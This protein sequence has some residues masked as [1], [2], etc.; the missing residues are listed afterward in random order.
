MARCGRALPQGTWTQVSD[1]G[2]YTHPK[3]RKNYR[4]E[5]C[6]QIIPKGEAH[7]VFTGM[8]ENEFQYWRMHDECKAGA[9]LNGDMHDGFTPYEA[10]RPPKLTLTAEPIRTVPQ[11]DHTCTART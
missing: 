4:C 9:E 2:G 11:T 5:W 3:G 1:F 7:Y 6:G 10:E 8:W